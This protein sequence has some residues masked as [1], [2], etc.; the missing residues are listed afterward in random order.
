MT[1]ILPAAVDAAV[2]EAVTRPI[3]LIRMAWATERRI[4]TFDIDISWDSET[5]SASGAVVQNIGPNGGTMILPIGTGLPWI[6]LANTEKLRGRAIEVYEYHTD[7]TASPQESDA[8]P[9]FSGTMDDGVATIKGLR[10]NLREGKKNRVFPP[11][12]IEPPTYNFL[13]ASGQRLFW[14]P[15]IITVET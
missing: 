7:F 4:A 10:V 11:G 14:G 2:D 1:R 6:G 5:W 3:H 13:L 9:I 12:N 8:T 15:D